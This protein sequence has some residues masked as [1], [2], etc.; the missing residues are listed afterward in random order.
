MAMATSTDPELA[1]RRLWQLIS[2]ALPIGAYSYSGGLEYAIEAGWVR[3]EA[4]VGDWLLGQLQTSQRQTDV[5]LLQRLIEAWRVPDPVRVCSL[6]EWLLACRETRELQAEDRH[7]GRALARLLTDLG[8]DEAQPW[9]QSPRATWATLYALA[10][11]RWQIDARA[12]IQAYL[13]A[14]CEN[15]V[16][17]AIK[18]V[19][20]GQTAG[21][22]LLFSLAEP[23]GQIAASGMALED[24]AI[25]ATAP[26][27]AIASSLHETQYSRLF[28]S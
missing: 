13:W 9:L 10:V 27:V 18:L 20:L 23:M 26:G 8:L 11:A 14:W 24:D 7:L 17:A 15:Q 28:R 5:P 12:A 21:Q 2:P 22:R 19:P 3:D 6:S 25:G 16:A 1:S 4:G